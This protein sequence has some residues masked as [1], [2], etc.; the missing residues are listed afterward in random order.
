M[1]NYNKILVIQ[2]AF[3]GDAILTTPLL[4]ELKVLFPDSIIDILC[5]PQTK[6]IFETNPNI[7]KILLFD[8]RKLFRKI[9]SIPKV[10]LKIRKEKY[11]LAISIQSSLTS[12]LFM[13]W[14]KIENRIGFSR[15]KFLTIPIPHTKGLHKIQKILRLLEPFTDYTKIPMQTE[16]FFTDS[17]LE[18]VRNLLHKKEKKKY[19][20]IAPG[21][22]WFTKRWFKE[23]FTELIAYLEKTE[24][25]ICLIGGKDDIDLCEEIKSNGK[26]LNFAGKLNIRE[27]AAL[28][29]EMDLMLTNDSAPLH[30]A[31]AVKTDVFAIFGP[32][33][34]RLGFYPYRKKDKII[35]VNFDCRPCGTHGG[36]KCPLGHHNC[37]R[38]IT[39]E[40]VFYLISRKLRIY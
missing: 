25:E 5:I 26:A 13:V 30:I 38:L 3:L 33:V 7:R 8:K 36:K 12:S 32:T 39:P 17:E 31:N 2:T 15:Q 6:I 10:I 35:E 4:R 20:G 19:I 37:M 28:I 1:K 40:Y 21:S 9:I 23:Y 22:I 16:I 34:K 14:G 18:K 11:D 24:V 27:S 29:S